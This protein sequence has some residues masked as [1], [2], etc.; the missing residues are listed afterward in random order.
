[1]KTTRYFVSQ[2]KP[3]AETRLTAGSLFSGAGLSDLGYEMAGFRFVAQ[4]EKN[5]LMLELIP[6]AQ[7]LKPRI[8]VAENVRPV[9]TLNVEYDGTSQ[10][11]ID[12]LRDQLSEYEVFPRVVNVADY[13]IP[14]VRRHGARE[15]L[16]PLRAVIRLG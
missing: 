14:Q 6:I 12:H 3:V 2:D 16:A 10:K 13:G 7:R 15:A 11:V 1:M 4:E 8:I 9:L 5:R